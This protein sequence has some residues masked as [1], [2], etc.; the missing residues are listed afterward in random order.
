[1]S[2]ALDGP[3]AVSSGDDSEDGGFVCFDVRHGDVIVWAQIGMDAHR[4]FGRL[5]RGR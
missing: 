4:T 3:S 5:H 2:R 1:M